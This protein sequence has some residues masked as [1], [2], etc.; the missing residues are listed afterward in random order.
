M[1]RTLTRTRGPWSPVPAAVST[2]S[3]GQTTHTAAGQT[4]ETELWQGGL[5]NSELLQD[6]PKGSHSCPTGTLELTHRLTTKG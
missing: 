4:K 3:P 2:S 1:G 5:R 6:S